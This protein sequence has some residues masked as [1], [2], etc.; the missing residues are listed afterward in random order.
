MGLHPM[1]GNGTVAVVVSANIVNILD[2][3]ATLKSVKQR[4]Y[5]RLKSAQVYVEFSERLARVVKQSV[6][7][8]KKAVK[9]PKLETTLIGTALSEKVLELDE[10][11][12]FVFRKSQQNWTWIALCATTRQVVAVATGDQ[13]EVTCRRLWEAVPD[14]Y[15][16]AHCFSDFWQAYQAVLPDAQHEAV[17]KE[18]GKTN[19]VE[20]WNN[21]LRQRLAQFVRKTLSFSKCPKMHFMRLLLFIHRYNT[22]L[23]ASILS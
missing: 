5:V 9:L 16:T 2:L 1:G 15:K 3:M 6:P 13:S 23:A 7:G 4:F 10:V 22:D 17:G 21:T 8:S 19:H 20:R 18:T 12:S 14:S 11:W